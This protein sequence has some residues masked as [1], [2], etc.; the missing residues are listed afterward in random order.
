MLAEAGAYVIDAD[1]VGHRVLEPSGAAY[2]AVVE[3]WPQVVA[4]GVIDRPALGRIVFADPGELAALESIT[5]PAI[6]SVISDRIAASEAP[7]VVVEVPLLTHF[8]G[9]G[10]LRVVVD[11]PDE[12]RR[13]RLIA[14][15]MTPADVDARMAAQPARHRWLE[16]ADIVVDNS[17]TLDDLRGAVGR[18]LRD[19]PGRQP[20]HS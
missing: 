6:R 12:E 19:L 3:R 14:R 17:G 1:E 15:G 2:A 16:A 8:L 7:L 10:W 13:R 11:A 20:P 5:H 4:D 18:L 9:E